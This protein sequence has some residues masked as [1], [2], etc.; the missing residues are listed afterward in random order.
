MRRALRLAWAAALIALF[1]WAFGSAHV[2]G[3]LKEANPEWIALAVTCLLAQTVA[4]ALRW[5]LVAQCLDI[6]FPVGWAIREYL[7]SQLA[8]TTLPGGVVGDGARAVRSQVGP[9]GLKRAAQAV[10]FERA[11]GQVGLLAVGIAGLTS[12][13]AAPGPLDWPAP[14]VRGIA[15]TGLVAAL[16]AGAGVIALRGG[17]I[18]ALVARCLPNGRVRV[19]HAALSI[20]AALLNVAAF[21]ACARAAGVVLSVQAIFVVIPLILT[22]MVIPLTVAGWGWREGAAAA[23]FPLAGAS[24]S[25]GVAASILFGIT[26]MISVLPAVPFLLQRSPR[27]LRDSNAPEPG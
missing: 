16:L 4:M 17:R 21:A 5:R 15:I 13:I 14:L 23:L 3:R 12:A 6:R 26:M 2:A 25:A 22:A 18:T 10:L 20:I 27:S 7:V 1:V 8:N 19:I 24:A 11:F 9:G